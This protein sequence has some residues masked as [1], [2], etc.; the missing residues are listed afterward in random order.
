MEL[1]KLVLV[2]LKLSS[3][4]LWFEPPTVV[5]WEAEK[6]YWTTEGFFD[7]KFDEGKQ[8][9]SFRTINFGIF[10]L[11]AFRFSNLPLQSWELRPEDA[12]KAVIGLSAAAVQAEF[13]IGEGTVTLVKFSSGNKPP[14]RGLLD[15]PMILKDLIKEMRVQGVDIF[16]DYDSHCYIEGLPLK[17]IQTE[18][19]LYNCMALTANSYNFTWSR[20]NLLSG[21]DKLIMQFR[22][23]LPGSGDISHQVMLITPENTTVLE[24]TEASQTFNDKPLEGSGYY[25]DLYTMMLDTSTP[26]VL[27]QMAKA[28]PVFVNTVYQFLTCSKVISYA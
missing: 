7:I 22:E 16:P 11:S 12:N 21:Y 1:Q 27:D 3:K 2:H 5:K 28:K 17:D 13:E 8:T 14:V 15:K 26:E 18:R 10:A 6:G 24:C 19:H 25:S 23:K 9:L 4:A 20:W